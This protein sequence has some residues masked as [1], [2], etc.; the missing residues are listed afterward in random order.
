MSLHC[1]DRT[2]KSDLPS[3]L[4]PLL[5][6]EALR[7]IAWATFYAD[8]MV[9]GGRHGFNVV[10]ETTFHSLQLPCDELNFLAGN[11]VMTGLLFPPAAEFSKD[12]P[13]QLDMSAYLLQTASARR[14]AL[15]FAFRATHQE[16][17]VEELVAELT[18]LESHIEGVIASLPTQLHFNT[19]NRLLHQTRLTTFL[20]LHILRHNLFII[21][22]RA[23]LQIYQ[24]EPLRVDRIL[25]ARRK[26]IAHALP[27][28][29]LIAEGLK[30]KIVFD[31]HVGIQ[32]Y[33]ALESTHSW[34]SI[35]LEITRSV[36]QHALILMST[37]LL[38]EPGR[39]AAANAYNDPKAPEL[40]VA[41]GHL[42]TVIRHLAA[43]SETSRR[44]VSIA[45]R[46]SH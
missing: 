32:A 46:F 40:E 22:G 18:E 7:R 24:R 6:R 19:H 43:R 14:R 17:T 44:M 25:D 2:Y 29:G 4:S 23:E 10:D 16:G 20:L 37:V 13:P 28:A 12:N 34:F 5:S 38:F 30:D 27:I 8:S 36:G 3:N 15:Y 33:V 9:D 35:A 1:F 41:M 45:T 39:L 11:N 26:R 21:V 31:P 42:I